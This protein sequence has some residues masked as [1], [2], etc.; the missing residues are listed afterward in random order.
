LDGYIRSLN[1]NPNV[2]QNSANFRNGL[3][4]LA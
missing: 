2:S 1:K 4:L 3:R